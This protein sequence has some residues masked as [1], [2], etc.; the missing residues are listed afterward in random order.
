MRIRMLALGWVLLLLLFLLIALLSNNSFFGTI[1]F[2]WGLVGGFILAVMAYQNFQ[3]GR[4]TVRLWNFTLA[5]AI[6]IGMFFIIGGI[7]GAIISNAPEAL[8]LPVVGV[9]FIYLASRERRNSLPQI[10]AEDRSP[11][12]YKCPNCGSMVP[13]S[14]RSCGN[15]GAV[16]WSIALR[17]AL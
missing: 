4:D 7:A 8:G 10:L 11:P 2:V 6:M 9:L 14:A 3:K 15:C 12:Q 1:F 5:I 16:V 13:R 17:T